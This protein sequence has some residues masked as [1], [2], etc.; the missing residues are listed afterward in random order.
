MSI[1]QFIFDFWLFT[2]TRRFPLKMTSSC[3][4]EN[5]LGHIR[6]INI[7]VSSGIIFLEDSMIN[8][9]KEKYICLF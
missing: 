9:F 7:P 6:R 4:L 1:S 8:V 2:N 5:E 3:F